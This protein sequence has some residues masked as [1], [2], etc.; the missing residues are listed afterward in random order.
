MDMGEE[1]LLYSIV[2][3]VTGVAGGFANMHRLERDLADASPLNR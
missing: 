3:V 1:C 2:V